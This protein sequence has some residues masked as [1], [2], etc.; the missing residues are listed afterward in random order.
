MQIKRMKCRRSAE[1]TNQKSIE[2]IPIEFFSSSFH[3]FFFNSVLFA[4]RQCISKK[5]EKQTAFISSKRK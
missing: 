1:K 4:N 2:T 5:Y 3:F